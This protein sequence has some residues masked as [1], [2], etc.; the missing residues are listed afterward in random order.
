MF[1][2]VDEGNNNSK[3][4]RVQFLVYAASEMKKDTELSI[5]Y[6]HIESSFQPETPD[7]SDS[8]ILTKENCFICKLLTEAL[9]SLLKIK[10]QPKFPK[11]VKD[12]KKLKTSVNTFQYFGEKNGKGTTKIWSDLNPHHSEFYVDASE[13]S[14]KFYHF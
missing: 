9:L 12:I 7:V 13:K 2:K 8:S 5:A 3:D 14:G 10:N 1:H 4:E 6:N 11:N